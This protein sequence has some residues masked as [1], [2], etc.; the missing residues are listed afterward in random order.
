[1]KIQPRH[2]PTIILVT[3]VVFLLLDLLL[4]FGPERDGGGHGKNALLQLALALG[5]LA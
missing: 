5:N 1:M 2:Y 3:Y 4:G